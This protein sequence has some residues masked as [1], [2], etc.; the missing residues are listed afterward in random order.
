MLWI[1]EV[2]MAKGGRFFFLLDGVFGQ[3]HVAEKCVNTSCDWFTMLIKLPYMVKWAPRGAPGAKTAYLP[4]DSDE[5]W[6]PL[7]ALIKMTAP[8]AHFTGADFTGA[9]FTGGQ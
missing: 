4:P 5:K 2:R 3:R 9:D 8:G 6:A 1:F 7:G